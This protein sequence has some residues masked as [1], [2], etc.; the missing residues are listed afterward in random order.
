M[1]NKIARKSNYIIES[2][3]RL[4]E[5]EQK[6]ITNLACQIDPMDAEFKEYALKIS[7]F[8][9]DT[10]SESHNT[11]WFME[12]LLEVRKQPL[13]IEYPN[14]IGKKVTIMTSWFFRIKKVEGAGTVHLTFDPLLK[15]FFLKLRERYTSFEWDIYRRLKGKYTLRMY[16]LLWGRFFK[17]NVIVFDYDWLRNTLGILP[18]ELKRYGNFKQIVLVKAQKEI[19]E[20]SNISFT[21]S[22]EKLGRAVNKIVF[23]VSEKGK[24]SNNTSV[25]VPE[26]QSPTPNPTLSLEDELNE[27]ERE[28]ASE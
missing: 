6:I 25:V 26:I 18:D 23:R 13:I 3:F 16:E 15:P 21:F 20:K 1:K 19:N 28:M 17:T 2:A 8:I 27:A 7:D 12:H 4:G 24:G 14:E 11:S 10:E 22:E 9:S 5:I